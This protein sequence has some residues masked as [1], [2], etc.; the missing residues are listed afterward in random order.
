LLAFDPV[1][2]SSKANIIDERTVKFAQPPSEAVDNRLAVKANRFPQ[3]IC[4]N[5]THAVFPRHE[6]QLRR[7]VMEPS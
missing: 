4:A 3:G 7:R 5:F 2:I 1:V 6:D